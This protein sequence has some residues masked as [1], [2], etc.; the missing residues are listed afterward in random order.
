M[1]MREQWR[2]VMISITLLVVA[3]LFY[4]WSLDLTSPSDIF[5]RLVIALL[6]T[7]S[8]SLLFKSIF[9]RRAYVKERAFEGKEEET[10]EIEGEGE[11]VTIR[12]W[13][14]IIAL[15]AF[16]YLIPVIGFYT[17]SFIF[18][19]VFIWYLDG[20]KTGI[21][22]VLRPLITAGGALIFIYFVFDDFLNIP[23]PEG[24]LF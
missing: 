10:E 24:I 7:F 23:V 16:V 19:G 9:V 17:V 13:A 2:D 5:P 22:N 18:M 3:G 11:K 15:I 12:K 6:L 21:F 8:I 1:L 20:L 14:G 4:I